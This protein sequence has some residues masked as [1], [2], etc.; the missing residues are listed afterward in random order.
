MLPELAADWPAWAVT[1]VLSGAVASALL[2]IAALA[3]KTGRGM[4]TA[5]AWLGGIVRREVVDIIDARL[6]PIL[7]ELSPNGGDSIK[8]HSRETRDLLVGHI[9]ESERRHRQQSERLDRH[10]LEDH[11]QEGTS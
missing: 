4:R 3:R 5:G 6:A 8:D 9:R 7:S 1:I 2:A 11:H 10:L